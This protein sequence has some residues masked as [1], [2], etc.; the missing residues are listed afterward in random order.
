M[1]LAAGAFE[2]AL[3]DLR[4]ADANGLLDLLWL[5]RCPLFAVLR[6]SAELANIRESTAARVDRI[7]RILTV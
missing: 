7:L 2:T 1:K 4:H 6:G 5:D 3:T